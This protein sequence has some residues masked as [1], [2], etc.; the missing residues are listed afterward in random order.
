MRVRPH[1]PARR[2]ETAMNGAE[3]LEVRPAVVGR[4]AAKGQSFNWLNRDLR[5]RKKCG[6][7]WHVREGRQHGYRAADVAWR[8]P[9]L[10]IRGVW[11]MRL[12]IAF[13]DQLESTSGYA[14]VTRSLW[15]I[16][17]GNPVVVSRYYE[18]LVPR[19]AIELDPRA[20]D[21]ASCGI[22]DMDPGVGRR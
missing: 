7:S 9:D 16:E 22:S 8:Q 13:P 3:G 20:A 11:R 14:Q 4:A 12:D 2:G 17:R 19:L 18:R 15:Q 6:A 1:P 10:E 21:I 5:G